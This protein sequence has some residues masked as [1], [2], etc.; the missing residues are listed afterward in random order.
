MLVVSFAALGLLW[1][2]PRLEE[3]E[4]RPL[5]GG[6]GK[7]I[8]SRPVEIVAGALGVA[9]LAVVIAAGF[10]GPPDPLSNFAPVFLLIVVWVGMAFASVLF[11]DVFRAFNPWRAIGRVALQARAPRR[12]RSARASGPP[13]PRC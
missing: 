11:G 10:A 4:W 1:S 13:P 12:T 2:R 8:A 3:D 5:P 7:L 9:L 6:I